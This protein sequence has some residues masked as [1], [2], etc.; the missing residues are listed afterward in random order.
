MYDFDDFAIVD[1]SCGNCSIRHFNETFSSMS[2]QLLVMNFNI[3]SFDSKYD[4]FSA[5]LEEI[6][7]KPHVLILTETW[8]SPTTCSEIQGYKA[9][10]CTRPGDNDRG[11]VSVFIL[12][13]LNLYFWALGKFLE[14]SEIEESIEKWEN[15]KS[16]FEISKWIYE[17][18]FKKCF[19]HF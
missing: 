6:N 5:F 13:T 18:S 1:G 16:N 9:Y 4:E 19:P 15:L 17:K 3:Q 11:G 10:H 14:A 8:F 12:D 2:N 7:L